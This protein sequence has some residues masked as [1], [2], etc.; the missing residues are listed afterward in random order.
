[1]RECRACRCAI[2]AGRLACLEHWRMLPARIR[3]AITFSYKTHRWADYAYNV[4]TA[5]DIWREAEVW[6]PGVPKV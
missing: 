1:M 4:A 6:K 5:D 2:P 3:Y